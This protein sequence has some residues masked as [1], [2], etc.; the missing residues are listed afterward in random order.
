MDWF[1]DYKARFEAVVVQGV[2]RQLLGAVKPVPVMPCKLQKQKIGRVLGDEIDTEEALAIDYY[3]Y[4]K[5]SRGFKRLVQEVGEN[6]K[7]KQ[8]KMIEVPIVHFNS[9]RLEMLAKV[10]LDVVA[11]FGKFKKA[12]LDAREFNH[13]YKV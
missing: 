1:E 4:V 9:V 13:N 8:V 12:V 11:D 10:A 7:G 6:Q 5:K 3:G 2:R